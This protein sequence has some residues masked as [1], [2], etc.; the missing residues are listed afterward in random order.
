MDRIFLNFSRVSNMKKGDIIN[1]DGELIK[2]VKRTN[3]E[4]RSAKNA[5]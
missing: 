2:I 3:C 5:H 1:N 4:K